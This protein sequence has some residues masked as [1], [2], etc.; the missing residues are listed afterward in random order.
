MENE[1][2]GK[3]VYVKGRVLKWFRDLCKGSPQECCPGEGGLVF[4]L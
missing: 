3:E 2:G 1:L 4:A